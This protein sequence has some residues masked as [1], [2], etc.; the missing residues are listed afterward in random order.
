MVQADQ[1]VQVDPLDREVVTIRDKQEAKDP[2]DQVLFI[3]NETIT[4]HKNINHRNVT[5]RITSE[6]LH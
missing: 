6:L 2:V 1:E 4:L 5:T 3:P